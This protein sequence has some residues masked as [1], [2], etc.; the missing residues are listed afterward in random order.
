MILKTFLRLE[1]VVIILVVLGR[2]RYGVTETGVSELYV[3]AAAVAGWG[4]G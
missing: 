4:A 2:C 1:G 3:G